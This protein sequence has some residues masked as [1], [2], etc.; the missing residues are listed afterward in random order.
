MTTLLLA[1][2]LPTADAA[3]CGTDTN[4]D[5]EG[6][7]FPHEDDCDDANANVNRN[8]VESCDDD[9][10]NNCDNLF[11]EGCE[12]YAN[13]GQLSGGGACKGGAGVGGTALLFAPLLALGWLR[14]KEET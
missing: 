9:I 12:T 10:D 5:C 3:S 11:N 14:R 8:Q 13:Q 6:D 4:Y 7:G 1:L 2:L